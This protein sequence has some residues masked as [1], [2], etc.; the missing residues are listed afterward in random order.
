MLTG[1]PSVENISPFTNI[2][3]T[4]K[5]KFYLQQL[6]RV[7]T[8]CN[9]L[10]HGHIPEGITVILEMKYFDLAIP[11]SQMPLELGAYVHRTI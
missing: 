11:E 6:Q 1:N 5:Y 2:K 10:S 9:K 8:H 7:S 3:Q 4:N